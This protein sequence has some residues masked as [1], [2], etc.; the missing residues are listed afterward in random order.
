MNFL[1]TTW[2][3][4]L[5][6]PMVLLDNPHFVLDNP[7]SAKEIKQ[8]A[9]LLEDNYHQQ[10]H[11]FF[12]PTAE[13][14][15]ISLDWMISEFRKRFGRAEPLIP[16]LLSHHKPKTVF[17]SFARLWVIARYDDEGQSNILKRNSKKMRK[18]GKIG[19]VIL[20]DEHPIIRNS[21][22]LRNYLS[23]LSLLIHSEGDD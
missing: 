3:Y 20:E 5:K 11:H 12:P 10:L 18:A 16:K 1:F 6:A 2:I 15:I 19:L 7:R 21:T 17:E 9:A 8:V 13:E 4:P 23:L 14:E 22:Y